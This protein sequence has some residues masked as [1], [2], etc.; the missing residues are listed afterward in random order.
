MPVVIRDALVMSARTCCKTLFGIWMPFLDRA[1]QATQYKRAARR[2]KA[3]Q[4]RL[5]RAGA[6]SAP[7]RPYYRWVI[8]TLAASECG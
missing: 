1:I 5:L 2:R 6:Q 4:H 8:V 7:N 3:L